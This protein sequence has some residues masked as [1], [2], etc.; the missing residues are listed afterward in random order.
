MENFLETKLLHTIQVQYQNHGG[1][2]SIEMDQTQTIIL[3]LI[4]I[5][6]NPP[7]PPLVD[8]FVATCSTWKPRPHHGR[9]LDRILSGLVMME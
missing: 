6:N 4:I 5:L 1:A 3:Y 8:H 2:T 7:P 9:H